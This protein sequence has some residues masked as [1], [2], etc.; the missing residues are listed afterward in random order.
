MDRRLPRDGDVLVSHSMARIDC[1]VAIL[2]RSA[3][4]FD[5]PRAAALE[6]AIAL[7]RTLGVDA[8]LTQD[9]RHFLPLASFRSHGPA[10]SPEAAAA[11]P[12]AVG[13]PRAHRSGPDR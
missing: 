13:T 10:V 1:E 8:W 4:A 6:S 2:P 7:A 5:Q 11:G 12:H 3:H 9:R